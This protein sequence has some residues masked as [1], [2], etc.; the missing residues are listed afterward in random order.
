[1]VARLVS[2]QDVEG[3]SPSAPTNF[4]AGKVFGWK[5]TWLE[6]GTLKAVRMADVEDVYRFES[7]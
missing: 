5:R 2:D 7:P 6:T 1:M 3:S 4:N